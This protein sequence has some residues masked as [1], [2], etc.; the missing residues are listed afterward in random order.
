MACAGRY[1]EASDYDAFTCAGIDLTDPASKL[2][3][4]TAL[5]IAAADIH[6]A[7]AAQGECDCALA[8]W[9]DTFLKKLNIIDAAILHNCPCGNMYSDD[10]KAN[11][12]EW[13]NT[14]LENI[15]TGKLELCDGETGSE[16]PA[17]GSI[18]QS[19]TQ[20]SAAEIVWNARSRH[21]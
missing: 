3:I 15:R 10:Q 7:M 18:E 12:L 11:L 13:V 21:S 20:W 16:F 4:E 17:F 5:D 1:A 2:S 6:A 8:S 9:A 14:N 19:L